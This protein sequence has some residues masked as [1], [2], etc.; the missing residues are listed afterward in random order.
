MCVSNFTIK[1]WKMGWLLESRKTPPDSNRIEGEN[2]VPNFMKLF[3]DEVKRL[4]R[5]ETKSA[6]TQLG[7]E[8][9]ELRRTIAHLKRRIEAL[10]LQNKR[11]TKVIPV[12]SAESEGSEQTESD[13]ARISPR[14]IIT[15]RKKL[16]LTQGELAKLVNV[17]GQSVYQWERK[18]GQL[19]LRTATR[20]A[21][22][23]LKKIGIREV[24]KRLEQS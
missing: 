14:T 16:N 15:L 10:E 11:L 1:V 22:V 9:V 6:V 21:I 17:S 2:I 4:A 24:R 8:K 19:R 13:R 7:K 18:D 12:E 5:K 3:Q 23:E 20:Q